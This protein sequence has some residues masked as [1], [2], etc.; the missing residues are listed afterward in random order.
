M[1]Q[2]MSFETA[3]VR[4]FFVTDF[5]VE[6]L[7]ARVGSHMKLAREQNIAVIFKYY[8]SCFPNLP[9]SLELRLQLSADKMHAGMLSVVLK[10]Q[11]LQIVK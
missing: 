3:F 9:G 8:N 11:M 7:I 6:Q 2:H 5:A 10:G 4:K 1:Q